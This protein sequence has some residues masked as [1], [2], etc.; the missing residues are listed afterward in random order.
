MIGP[1]SHKRTH[2]VAV[3]DD[4]GRR[5]GVRDGSWASPARSTPRP[6]RGRRCGIPDLPIAVLDGPAGDVK[7]MPVNR[8]ELVGQRTRLPNRLRWHLH[9]LDR[10]RD[11]RAKADSFAT[12]TTATRLAPAVNHAP[13]QSGCCAA[14]C[15]TLDSRLCER[16][17]PAVNPAASGHHRRTTCRAPLDIP[18]ATAKEKDW[19]TT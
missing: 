2:T 19:Q 4:V 13:R 6:L 7:L 3:L 1:D 15:P 12:N 16:R 5:L 10:P 9:A 8:H 18:G 17:A 11:A 14:S